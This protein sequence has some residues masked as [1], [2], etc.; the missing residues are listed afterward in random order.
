MAGQKEPHD[1]AR[2]FEAVFADLEDTCPGQMS[3]FSATGC[4]FFGLGCDAKV[5]DMDAV[6]LGVVMVA[7]ALGPWHRVGHRGLK[8]EVAGFE[9]E[10]DL[11]SL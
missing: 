5:L 2:S 9:L 1:R 10:G 11:Q 7:E 6:A 3:S 4:V 8:E